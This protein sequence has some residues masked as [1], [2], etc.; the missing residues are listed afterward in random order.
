MVL[1]VFCLNGFDEKLLDCFYL[2]KFDV[3]SFGIVC[4]EIFIGDE[5]FIDVFRL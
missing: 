2:K 3:Y 1:E 4:Y 5:L